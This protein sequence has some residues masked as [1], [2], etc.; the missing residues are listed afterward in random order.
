MSFSVEFPR[1]A[2]RRAI[3]VARRLAG[4]PEIIP[5]DRRILDRR[6]RWMVE[7]QPHWSYALDPKLA[8]QAFM[9]E[10]GYQTPESYGQLARITDLPELD[11]LP[12]RFVLKP[13]SGKSSNNVFL[14]DHGSSLLD[15]VPMSRQDIIDKVGADC[16]ESF[17][18]E[19]LLVNFDGRV[20]APWDFKFYCFGSDI[21]LIVVIERNDKRNK[22]LNR[23]WY[24]YPDW[25]PLPFPLKTKDPPS[26]GVP[27]RPDCMDEMMQVARTV[28]EELGIFI[29]I[30]MY[31]TTRGVVFGEFTAQPSR[32]LNF[33]PEA[34]EFLGRKWVGLEGCAP[35]HPTAPRPL[36]LGSSI[37]Q[38]T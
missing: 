13:L 31:A 3:R 24:L 14:M 21:A 37:P 12:S 20:G 26:P 32:G 17:L 22:D 29:R 38:Q 1:R 35:R 2:W 10:R 25:T 19:E 18:L 34:N 33:T 9:R 15:R 27:P 30:D 5:F 16:P 11:S 8:G 23:Y 7:G 36:S 6:R 4:Q 28:G